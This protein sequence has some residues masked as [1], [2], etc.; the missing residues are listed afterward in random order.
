MLATHK[1]DN[2]YTISKLFSHQLIV[3]DVYEFHQSRMTFDFK[4]KRI[5]IMFKQ[6]DFSSLTTYKV[7]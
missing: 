6:M 3:S 5:I 1:F 2:F 4:S 7:K